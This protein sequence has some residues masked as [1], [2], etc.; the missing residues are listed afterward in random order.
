MAWKITSDALCIYYKHIIH[1]INGK[2]EWG[3]LMTDFCLRQAQAFET[4]GANTVFIMI[5]I[6]S[7]SFLMKTTLYRE[8]VFFNSVGISG[9]SVSAIISKY[10]DWFFLSADLVSWCCVRAFSSP[11][12]NETSAAR[13]H[14]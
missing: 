3:Q 11:A 1:V 6:I 9:H 5:I 10:R 13:A 14:R 8:K 2:S 4:H 12:D 7:R